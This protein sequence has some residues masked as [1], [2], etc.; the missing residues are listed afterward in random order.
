MT[1]AADRL[2]ASDL[3]RYIDRVEEAFRE[4]D[5]LVEVVRGGRLRLAS[6]VDLRIKQL[7][8]VV[9]HLRDPHYVQAMALVDELKRA[10]I[11]RSVDLAKVFGELRLVISTWDATRQH[12]RPFEPVVEL[13]EVD[14]LDAAS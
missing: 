7:V 5:D 10:R 4:G 13:D 12:R 14:L 6:T 9:V 3:Y 1:V 11:S 8:D 2:T